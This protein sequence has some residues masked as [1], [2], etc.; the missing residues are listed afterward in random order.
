MIWYKLYNAVP[1]VPREQNKKG[2]KKCWIIKSGL[3]QVFLLKPISQ[4]QDNIRA[5]IDFIKVIV[6]PPRE[7]GLCVVGG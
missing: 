5:W 1:L 2:G 7:V 6:L 4:T 3:F